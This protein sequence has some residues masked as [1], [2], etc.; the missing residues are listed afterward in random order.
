MTSFAGLDFGNK[1]CVVG[2]PKL[3]SINVLLDQNSNRLIPTMVSY[4]ET[5]RLSGSLAQQSILQNINQTITQLK[6]LVCLQFDSEE[7]ELMQK[8]VFYELVKL[9]DGFTGVKLKIKEDSD[10]TQVLRPEQFLAFLFK[11]LMKTAQIENPSISA[12]AITVS[13]WW[14]DKHRRCIIDACKISKVDLVC[15]VNSTTAAAIGYVM[16][17]RKRLPKPEEESVPVAFVDLG[18]SSLNVAIALLK[19]DSVCIKSFAS[20]KNLGGSHFTNNL[21]EYL[22]EKTKEKYKIDPRETNRML[23][24]FTEAT[25]KLKKNLTVNSSVMF[26]VIGLKG[27]TDVKFLVKREEFETNIT[28]LLPLLKTPIEKAMKLAN[29]KSEDLFAVEVLGG[30]SRVPAVKNEL[31]KV[32]GREPET[33]LNLD[34]CFAVGCGYYAAIL[35][36]ATRVPLT[37]KDVTPHAISAI[38]KDADGDKVCELFTQFSE[39]PST[40]RLPI[41]IKKDSPTTK[42]L[43]KTNKEEICR[44]E[45]ETPKIESK[46]TQNETKE[47]NNKDNEKQENET[48]DSSQK[49][50]TKDDNDSINIQIRVNLTQSSTVQVLG[51]FLVD[52][53][54]NVE[55]PFT[56]HYTYGLSEAQINQF[57]AQELQLAQKDEY[58]NKVDE[59]RNE[60]ESYIFQ[61]ERGIEREFPDCF[62][63]EE[64]EKTQNLIKTI[65]SWFEEHEFERLPLKEYETKLKDLQDAAAPAIQRFTFYKKELNEKADAI[66]QRIQNKIE[67]IQ[68][69]DKIHKDKKSEFQNKA[70]SFIEKFKSLV[71]EAKQK[72]PYEEP[73]FSFSNEE[74]LAEEI[75][76]D[77]DNLIL[78]FRDAKGRRWC[79]IA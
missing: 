61:T 40:K 45:I 64:K 29:V 22:I 58:E 79:S 70:N 68:N 52:Q 26:E 73:S 35:N 19:Q 43:L 28:D 51:A 10:E 63:P 54:S 8:S 36:P 3:Y 2:V 14:T 69:N 74:K 77:A 20:N 38:W 42:V 39:V 4:T 32:F 62:V 59:T 9:E 49:E 60:L 16:D 5:R 31:T 24:R 41:H 11:S 78:E 18:D 33:A 34:E 46:Q 15:L 17:H 71:E 57:Q 76:S 12:F 30:G 21:L 50:E 65:H 23:Y 13:P 55:I 1:N 48:K 75:E 56:C 66:L 53:S 37:V 67:E 47:E 6:R 25:E 72:K 44:I 27:D 7:R